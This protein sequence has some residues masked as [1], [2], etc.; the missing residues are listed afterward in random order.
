MLEKCKALLRELDE[1]IAESVAQLEGASE[2]EFMVLAKQLLVELQ[3]REE[4]GRYMP[5]LEEDVEEA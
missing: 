3:L 5:V 1:R 4:L 2:G